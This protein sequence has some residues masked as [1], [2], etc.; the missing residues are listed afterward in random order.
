MKDLWEIRFWDVSAMGHESMGR[1]VH[2][3]T[4][5]LPELSDLII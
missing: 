4:G 3:L 2:K 5:L 1:I